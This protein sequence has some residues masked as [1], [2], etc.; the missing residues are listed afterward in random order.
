M[1]VS[2]VYHEKAALL[3]QGGLFINKLTRWHAERDSV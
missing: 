3:I 2:P 1:L